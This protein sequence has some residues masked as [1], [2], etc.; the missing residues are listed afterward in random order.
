[1][2]GGPS[3]VGIPSGGVSREQLLKAT[4]PMRILMDAALQLMLSELAPADLMALGDS[5]KCAEYAVATGDAF[6]S[7]FKSLRVVPMMDKRAPRQGMI[8][9][10]DLDVLSGKEM[11]E[12]QKVEKKQLCATLGFFYTRVFQIYAALALTLFDDA[13]IRPTAVSRQGYDILPYGAR[14]A[15]AKPGFGM[16]PGVAVMRGGSDSDSGSISGGAYVPATGANRLTDEDKK[17]LGDTIFNLFKSYIVEKDTEAKKYRIRYPEGSYARSYIMTLTVPDIARPGRTIGIL[18]L[19]T[20]IQNKKVIEVYFEINKKE[21]GGVTNYNVQIIAISLLNTSSGIKELN[22][23]KQL[24]KPLFNNLSFN[25][26]RG[27]GI[28]ES[29]ITISCGVKTLLRPL[30][31]NT[32]LYRSLMM[33]YL[34]Q[35]LIIDK[36]NNNQPLPSDIYPCRMDVD[37]SVLNPAAAAA[38]KPVEDEA[39]RKLREELE[40]QK[41]ELEE[42]RARRYDGSRYDGSRYGYDDVPKKRPGETDRDYARRLKEY[43]DQRARGLG[44]DSQRT[45]RRDTED[46]EDYLDRLKRYIRELPSRRGDSRYDYGYA[47]G[48]LSRKPGESEYEYQK[49]VREHYREYYKEDRESHLDARIG[50]VYAT[51]KKGTR[52]IAHCVARALQLVSFDPSARYGRSYVCNYKFLEPTPTGLPKPGQA[53]SEST[54]LKSLS[55]LF[56]A[57]SKGQILYQ[58]PGRTEYLNFLR[59]MSEAFGDDP[60]RITDSI[61]PTEGEKSHKPLDRIVNKKDA[62]GCQRQDVIEVGG[63]AYANAVAASRIL[64]ARQVKHARDVEQIFRELFII[65]KRVIKIHPQLLALG[66]PGL[67][68]IA[69]KTRRVL[70][71][72]YRE[73]EATYQD[74]AAAIKGA[75]IRTKGGAGSTGAD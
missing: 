29:F 22:I 71:Q 66:L 72:Y 43:I 51:L 9:F 73:C 16:G 65:D 10:Q 14:A 63:K 39:S 52:P 49:R 69:T 59:G 33:L 12:A 62:A 46:Y 41:K 6:E 38:P 11:T 74:A 36:L 13:N 48:R 40:K 4:Q 17:I 23:N 25:Y 75:V 42:L 45:V 55:T 15:A 56:A 44:W 8:Y 30:G 7:Y 67:D 50:E 58:D 47:A 32:T 34:Y 27:T 37:L 53:I 18:S 54:G 1:M 26:T 31:L 68:A 64:M 28:Q 2:G 5:G 35:D 57:F 3:K 21:T 70:A 61:L 24:H 19:D 60:A 20:I